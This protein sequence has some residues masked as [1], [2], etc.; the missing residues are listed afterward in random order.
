MSTTTKKTKSTK[1]PTKEEKV[2]KL[3]NNIKGGALATHRQCY[4]PLL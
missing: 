2:L 4:K 1:K 3:K